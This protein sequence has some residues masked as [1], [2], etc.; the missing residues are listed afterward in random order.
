MGRDQRLLRRSRRPSLGVRAHELRDDARRAARPRLTPSPECA[1]DVPVG[2]ALGNVPAL[3]ALLLAARDC[4]LDLGAAVLEIE[5][6]WDDRQ[7]LF[8][9]LA[10]QRVELAPVHE[11]LAV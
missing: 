4:E 8:L 7:S 3:V 5:L 11:Q 2:V 1:L 10:D 6:R 9:H